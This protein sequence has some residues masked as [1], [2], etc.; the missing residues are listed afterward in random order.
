MNATMNTTIYVARHASPDWSRTDIPYDVPPGPPLTPRGEE[1][2]TLLGEFLH[3][4][5]VQ[6]VVSS[7]MQRAYQTAQLAA[8]VL[9]LE[10]EV[11]TRITEQ[12]KDEED[13]QVVER[14]RDFWQ[15]LT[16]R[17]EQQGPLCIVTHGGVLGALLWL[18]GV[19]NETHPDHRFDHNTWAPPSGA[20]SGHRATGTS[21]WRWTLDYIPRLNKHNLF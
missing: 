14:V 9:G 6:H 8:A 10:A 15:E 1:E 17:A 4:Q 20:W 11:E 2:S 5:G 18:Q 16:E 19:T 21:S 13:R 3:M 12:R 7:P